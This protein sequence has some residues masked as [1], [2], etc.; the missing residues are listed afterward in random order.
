MAF[1]RL[2][3][4]FSRTKTLSLNEYDGEIMIETAAYDPDIAETL[5]TLKI[6]WTGGKTGQGTY[7]W[8]V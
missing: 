2:L 3:E 8:R 5:N 7:L 6:A 1:I 4:I